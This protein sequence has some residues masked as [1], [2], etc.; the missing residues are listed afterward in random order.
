MPAFPAAAE[1]SILR[2]VSLTALQGAT[3]YGILI[4]ALRRNNILRSAKAAAA[5][6][7]LCLLPVVLAVCA[8]SPGAGS[9][10][11][12]LTDQDLRAAFAR[13]Q[14]ALAA[15]DYSTAEQ[16]NNVGLAPGKAKWK[17]WLNRFIP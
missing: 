8:Q 12:R 14:Q 5:A 3:D 10:N 4:R 9:P 7:L 15:Q 2:A 6:I 1:G 17:S 11:R 13:A 16:G